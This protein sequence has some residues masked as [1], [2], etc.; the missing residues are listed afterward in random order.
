MPLAV[1]SPPESL[2]SKAPVVPR[3]RVG[4][5]CIAVQGDTPAELFSRAEEAVKDSIFIELRLDRLAKPAAVFPALQTFLQHHRVL[6]LIATCRRKSFGGHFVGS[7][8][9]ELDLL[10]KA[11]ETG[12]HIVD[13][14]VESAEQATKP[15]LAR[16]RAALRAA[17]TA[18][19]ISSHDFSRTRRPDGLIQ[20][21]Q[22]IAEFEP[23]YVKVVTTARSLADN[24]SVLRMVEDQSLDSQIVG[25]AM[26]EEGVISR[27]LSPRA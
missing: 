18:L 12:C 1:S 2:P 22:R 27:I 14:E 24:L 16:F 13:L 8:N 23:D 5:L 26:G 20:N 10:L 3:L 6:T 19:L 17:G 11:A 25:I 4:K 21:A 15:Q 9:A 7:L